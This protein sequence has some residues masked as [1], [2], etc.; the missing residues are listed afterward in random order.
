MLWPP[1]S[2]RG[3]LVAPSRVITTSHLWPPSV[4][5]WGSERPQDEERRKFT[6]RL[7]I[8]SLAS[9]VLSHWTASPSQW[10]LIGRNTLDKIWGMFAR[11][12]ISVFRHNLQRAPETAVA[13]YLKSHRHQKP[14]KRSNA[15]A[16]MA[17]V[18]NPSVH[19]N[20]NLQDESNSWQSS[21]L[22]SH[23]LVK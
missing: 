8:P 15:E 7:Q 22:G 23:R 10:H 1:S 11:P 6:P 18:P 14:N 16:A 17:I 12:E 19:I 13:T 2:H 5:A 21:A 3:F 9:P 4:C 20:P